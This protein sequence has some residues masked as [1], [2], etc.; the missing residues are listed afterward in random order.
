MTYESI[1]YNQNLWHNIEKS[2]VRFVKVIIKPYLCSGIHETPR[3]TDSYHNLTATCQTARRFDVI[4]I[5]SLNT[6]LTMELRQLKYFIGIAETG[7]FSEAS[8]RFYLSQSA[9]S[10]QI[11]LLEEELGTLLFERTSHRVQLTESGEMLLPLARNVLQGVSACQERLADLKGM[12]CGELSIGMTYSIDPLARP[13]LTTFLKLYPKVRLNLSYFS[14]PE[15]LQRLR[16]GQ[17]DIAFSVWNGEGDS[18]I[19]CEQVASYRLCAIMRDTHPLANSKELSFRDMENQ[20]F[21]LPEA[22]IRDRNAV[23]QYLSSDAEN[24]SV[25]AIVNN[26]HTIMTLLSHTNYISVL[27]EQEVHGY[28]YLRAVC[29]KEL[30]DP[31]PVYAHFLKNGYRK[32]SAKTFLKLLREAIEMASSRMLEKT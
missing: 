29:I 13:A 3:F 12:L 14:I 27:S 7:S 5:Y 22:G 20:S 8:R 17:L 25:R 10:Q 19:V 16:A 18:Q 9:I 30:A 6:P 28:P 1:A 2:A 21:V 26:P 31:V 23:E 15:L 24:L 4:I 32:Q 11:K